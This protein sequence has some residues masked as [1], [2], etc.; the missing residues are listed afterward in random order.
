MSEMIYKVTPRKLRAYMM[1]VLEA[2]L[3][4]YISGP[5]GIGKS[6]ITHSIGNELKLLMRDMRISTAAPEDLSGLPRIGE[7][8]AYTVPFRDVF[9]IQ[10]LD[11]VPDGYEGW[12]L[13]MD[14]MS[15][16]RKETIAASYKVLLDKMVGQKKIHERC[17]IVGAG[18]RVEDRAIANAL[19]TAAES[20]L[21]HFEL[22]V[23]Y[24]EWLEDVA[25]AQNY[26]QRVI[27]YLSQYESDLMDFKPDHTG[28]TFCCPR[29]WEFMNRLIRDKEVEESKIALYS[30]TIT[31]SVASKFTIFTKVY[32]DLVKIESILADPEGTPVPTNTSLRWATITMMGEHIKDDTF[33]MLSKY[34]NKFPMEFRVLFFRMTML[35]AP[36]M[37]SHPWFIQSLTQLAQYLNG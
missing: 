28:F 9:P 15:S 4:P 13:F 18:N 11:E 27:A 10:G 1:D 20:R 32:N 25:I 37:R 3:V 26:D 36:Q 14:E 8:G 30:G 34:A 7:N 31:S 17:L 24:K 5:P 21:V 33:E 16:G 35:R 22:E 12:L 6:A 19:G 29:T 23:S 2:G